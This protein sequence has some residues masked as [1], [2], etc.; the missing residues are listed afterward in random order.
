MVYNSFL[1]VWLFPVI[2]CLYHFISNFGQRTRQSLYFRNLFLLCTSYAL[3]YYYNQLM[4]FVLLA[5]TLVSYT[6]AIV[7]E[8]IPCEHKRARQFSIACAVL[9]NLLPLLT[10]KYYDFFCINLLTLGI[11]LK[12]LTLVAP[13]GISFFTFQALG[14]LF[15]VY[16]KRITADHHILNYTLFVSFFPSITSGPINR[17]ADIAPQFKQPVTFRYDRITRG[18]RML[19]WGMFLKVVI[20]DRLALYSRP[21][22]EEYTTYSGSSLLMASILYTLQIYADFAGYSLQAIGASVLLGIQLKQNFCRPYFA[23]SVG[24]FWRRWHISLSQWLRDYVYIPLGG[25]RCSKPRCYV[26]IM[27]TF[28]VSGIWHG[29]NWTFI[30]WGLL[31]GAAQA[32]EKAVGIKPIHGKQ[33]WLQLIR[34]AYTFCFVNLAWIFFNMPTV[35]DACCVIERIFCDQDMHFAIF[36]KYIV[37]FILMMLCRDLACELRPASDP[38]E[39]KNPIVRWSTYIIVFTSIALFGVFDSSQF[40]YARF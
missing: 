20:A 38:L 26:N 19:L 18:A 28:L 37:V 34:I 29:A 24:D 9:L 8:K 35:K 4:V 36:E 13:L 15:D 23:Q 39:H 33:R 11:A 6:S 25:S 12:P 31:H 5:V 3:Y 32:L 30:L 7:I 14:Y 17:Y 21:V 27:I 1:F 16:N 2:F 40:I 10:F 22:F